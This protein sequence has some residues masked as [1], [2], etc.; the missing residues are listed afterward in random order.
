MPITLGADMNNPNL[1]RTAVY[2]TLAV[3]TLAIVAW[4]FAIGHASM[5]DGAHLL[6]FDDDYS[7]SVLGWMIAIPVLLFTAI[8][9]AVILAG[10]GVLMVGALAMAA[11]AALLAVVFAILLSVLPVAVFIAIPILA[12][13]GMVKLIR[14]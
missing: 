10:A 5:G 7:D 4:C 11:V 2:A 14:D 12:V 6:F 9:V 13:V 3:V 1:S 8:L